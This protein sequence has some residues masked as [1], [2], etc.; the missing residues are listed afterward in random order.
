MTL[1]RP[2]SYVPVQEALFRAALQWFPEQMAAL[3]I[4]A[5]GELG[6]DE[7]NDRNPL[8]PIEK[9][10][11]ILGQ[12]SISHELRQQYED[13]LTQTEHRFRNLLYQGVLIGYYF[14]VRSD[15]RRHAVAREF[16]ATT[17]ADGVLMSGEYWPSGKGGP[18]YE[19]EPS[20]PLFFLETELT[21][22]L[23]DESKT[24]T[25][26]L[27]ITDVLGGGEDI[28]HKRVPTTAG[29]ESLA[30]KALAS[31]LKSNPQMRRADAA[32]WCEKAG[33]KLG[34]RAFGRVWPQARD[35]AGLSPIAPPGRKPKPP[36]RN[37]HA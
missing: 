13:I 8:T 24:P 23:G 10:A 29:Q 17:E 25:S 20:C 34:K 21:A 28:P 19:R 2:D 35:K 16:W 11:H 6:K 7:P 14:G 15:R 32:E 22:F 37:H 27:G 4:A 30:I 36:R 31:H 33:H 1:F 3:E 9:F 18:W 26:D 12:P 5:I